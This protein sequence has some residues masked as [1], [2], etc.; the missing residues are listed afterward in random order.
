M[1]QIALPLAEIIAIL[2]LCLYA[3][4]SARHFVGTY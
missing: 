4:V 3:L 1:R 2:V